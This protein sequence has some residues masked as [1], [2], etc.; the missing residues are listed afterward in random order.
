[1][2]INAVSVLELVAEDLR[3]SDPVTYS[4]M[5]LALRQGSR[6]EVQITFGPDASIALGLRDDYERTRWVHTCPLQ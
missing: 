4:A 2:N 5:E 6:A 3:A 1:M